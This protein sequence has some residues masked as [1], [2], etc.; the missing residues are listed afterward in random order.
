MVSGDK[1]AAPAG[2]IEAFACRMQFHSHFFG[3][4]RRQEA[5]RVPFKDQ[6]GVGRI[7]NHDQPMF[8]ANATALAKNSGVALLRSD[9]SDN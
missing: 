1:A 9:C 7:V 3:A 2:H 8:V 6:G 4:G 5:Q